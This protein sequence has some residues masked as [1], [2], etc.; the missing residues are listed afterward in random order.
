MLRPAVA[1]GPGP[2]SVMASGRPREDLQVTQAVDS[3]ILGGRGAQ[4]FANDLA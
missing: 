2:Q 1:L 4:V 3:G